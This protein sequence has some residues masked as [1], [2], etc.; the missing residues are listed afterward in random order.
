MLRAAKQ[1]GPSLYG[2]AASLYGN[3]KQDLAYFLD[4][5]DVETIECET[6]VTQGCGLGTLL[7]ALAFHECITAELEEDQAKADR[8]FRDIMICAYADDAAI[9]GP[10]TQILAFAERLAQ[11]LEKEAALTVKEHILHPPQNVER[12]TKLYGEEGTWQRNYLDFESRQKVLY[13]RAT[14][15]AVSSL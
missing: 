7:F 11:R 4:G 2:F 8:E 9:T 5:A 3:G 6:G 12:Q 13:S 10:S 14:R 15:L 1:F